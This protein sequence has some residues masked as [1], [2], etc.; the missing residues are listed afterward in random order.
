MSDRS[1]DL[2]RLLVSVTLSSPLSSLF[3]MAL[4]G[5]LRAMIADP[6]ELAIR[7]VFA[8][9]VT[10]LV[11][12]GSVLGV[13]FFIVPGLYLSARWM[14]AGPMVLLE[15]CGIIEAMGRSWRLTKPAAWPLVGAIV[16]LTIPNLAIQLFGNLDPAA[17]LDAINPEAVLQIAVGSALASLSIAISVFASTE[18]TDRMDPLVETFA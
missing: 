15:G 10:V 1:L 4:G 12:I 5:N 7:L 13:I 17:S 6:V 3:V 2:A 9:A 18:L 14:I 16:V 11:S 8:L